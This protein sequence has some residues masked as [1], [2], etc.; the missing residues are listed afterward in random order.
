MKQVLKSI[1]TIFTMMI[2]SPAFAGGLDVA[3]DELSTFNTWLYSALG[4]AVVTYLIYLVIGAMN[5]RANGDWMG[6]A[7]GCGIVMLGGGIVILADH[8]FA[9]GASA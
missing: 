5:P 1:F 6:V 7:K 2:F 9:V 4:V 8:L 3:S